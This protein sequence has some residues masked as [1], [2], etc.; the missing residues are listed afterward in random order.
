[1]A[2]GMA[3]WDGLDADTKT[4]IQT[5]AKANPPDRVAIGDLLYT[6]TR[7]RLGDSPYIVPSVI[8]DTFTTIKAPEVIEWVI[9][10]Q[11]LN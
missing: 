8:V 10:T 2:F 7:N 9:K 11:N 4:K 3:V 1:M 5:A 6:P